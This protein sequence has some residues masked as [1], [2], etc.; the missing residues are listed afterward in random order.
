MFVHRI[1]PRD[2]L[3]SPVYERI[4]KTRTTYC[5]ANKSWDPGCRRQPLT[6][7]LVVLAAPQDDTA[8]FVAVAT[9]SGGDDFLTVL[10]TVKSLDLPNVWFNSL[11]LQSLDRLNHKAGTKIEIIRFL[12]SLQTGE[13]RLFCRH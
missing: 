1:F 5:E 2:L 3:C 11:I 9:A 10:S 12:V 8:D 6:Y 7:F 4:P 13:L